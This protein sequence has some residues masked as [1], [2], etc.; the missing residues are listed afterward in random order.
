MIP[1]DS[2]IFCAG[3]GTRM[4][5]Y[6]DKMPKSLLPLSDGESVLFKICRKLKGIGLVDSIVNYSW[7]R[8][9]FEKEA[10][11]IKKDLEYS[12]ILSSEPMPLGHGGALL[13]ASSL[14]KHEKILGLNG[15]TITDFRDQDIVNSISLCTEKSP[16]IAWVTRVNDCGNLTLSKK[17]G[18]IVGTSDRFPQ[19]LQDEYDNGYYGV[20]VY[21]FDSTVTSYIKTQGFYSLWN[22]GGLSDCIREDGKEVMPYIVHNLTQ[23]SVGTKEEYELLLNNKNGDQ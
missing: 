17:H 20:G 19:S 13:Q 3:Y 12:I 8:E 9:L 22:E 1:I 6:S 21:M 4:K 16:M 23:I 2:F 5:P 14:F 11:R 15:D 7:G 18:T 10:I